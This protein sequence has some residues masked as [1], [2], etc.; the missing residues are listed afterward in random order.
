M[1]CNIAVRR[2][3][4]ITQ[5][6]EV[7]VCAANAFNLSYLYSQSESF[8]PMPQSR[9]AL[10]SAKVQYMWALNLHELFECADLKY[11]KLRSMVTA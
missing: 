10:L 6:L 8:M 7:A 4:Q 1:P 9:V 11:C 3:A 2:V 5:H